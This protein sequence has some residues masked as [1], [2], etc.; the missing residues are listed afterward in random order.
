MTQMSALAS[1]TGAQRPQVPA[2]S[3]PATMA[4]ILYASSVTVWTAE[5]LRNIDL[6][7]KNEL[8]TA[9]TILH[10]ERRSNFALGPR[11]AVVA[12]RNVRLTFWCAR[13]RT[14]QYT[15][16]SV[17]TSRRSPGPVIQSIIFFSFPAYAHH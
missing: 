17:P 5:N 7:F 3:R 13:M 8:P 15:A 2:V 6:R 14:C 16:L 1:C 10:D 11:L 4:T 9:K 12:A